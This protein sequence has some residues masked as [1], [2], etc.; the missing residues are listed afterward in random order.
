MRRG[1]GP[2]PLSAGVGHRLPHDRAGRPQPL[3]AEAAPFGI[4]VTLVEPGA[5]DTLGPT[6]APSAGPPLVEDPYAPALQA[7]TA[8]RSTPMTSEEVALSVAE[9]IENPEVPF[10]VAV[11][12]SVQALIE[13]TTRRPTATSSTSPPPGA[14]AL[15]SAQTRPARHPGKAGRTSLPTGS[16]HRDRR[17]VGW[18]RETLRR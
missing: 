5:V 7:L 8:L 14:D 11:G 4:K 2:F 18:T 17:I 3:A 12:G 13:A 6:A 16:E 9:V 1:A 10:R 15:I